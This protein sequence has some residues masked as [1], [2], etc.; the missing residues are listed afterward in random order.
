MQETKGTTKAEADLNQTQ[1]EEII[2]EKDVT[3][4]Y[5]EYILEEGV[6][7]LDRKVASTHVR[8]IINESDTMAVLI[9]A[10]YVFLLLKFLFYVF[11]LN[12]EQ[13]NL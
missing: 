7:C 12:L 6:V 10:L 9:H 2:N 3:S 5:H 13:T 8:S 4:M 1:R 11:I